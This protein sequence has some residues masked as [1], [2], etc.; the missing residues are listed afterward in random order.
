MSLSHLRQIMFFHNFFNIFLLPDSKLSR[1]FRFAAFYVRMIH[2]LAVSTVYASEYTQGEMIILGIINGLLITIVLKLMELLSNLK[3]IGKAISSVFLMSMLLF[4]YYLILSIVSGQEYSESNTAFTSYVIVILTDLLFT[5]MI[6][7]IL[8]RFAAVYVLKYWGKI[9]HWKQLF[10]FLRLQIIL[11]T[12][13][14]K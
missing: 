5:S 14:R 8:M 10:D 12:I 7:A 13:M 4:Y 2:S 9:S 11:S 1:P 3:R 6:V